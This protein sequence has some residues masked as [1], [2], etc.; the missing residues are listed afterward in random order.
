MRKPLFG[1]NSGTFS[2]GGN[3]ATL[4]QRANGSWQAVI[5]RKGFPNQSGTFARKADAEAWARRIE[6]T[7]DERTFVSTALSERMTFAELA[8]NFEKNF[9]PHHYRGGAWKYKLAHLREHFGAYAL[10]VIT[11]PMVAKYRDKRLQ[12]PDPRYKDKEAAPRVSGGTVKTEIDLLSSVL[13]WAQKELHIA[14]PGGNPVLGIRKPKEGK[15]RNR[16]IRAGEWETL[17][18][19]CLASRNPMLWKAVQLSVETAVRQGELLAMD[20][21]HVDFKKRNV[22]IPETKIGE[23][24]RV[25]LSPKAIEILKEMSGIEGPIFDS[26][27]RTIYHAFKAACRRAGIV[28]LTWHDLRHEALSRLGESGKYN[29]FELASISGHKNLKTLSRYIHVETEAIAKKMAEV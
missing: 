21:K 28:G 3:V 16:R 6:A 23:S 4:K 1:N 9:A 22:L 12:D 13:G 5:R 27:R 11:P 2:G 20:L 10:S 19:E 17:E 26:E 25:P 24:R 15:A 18:R 7:M 14:L 29:V 8:E